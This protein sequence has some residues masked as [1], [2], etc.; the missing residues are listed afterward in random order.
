MA[1]T[2][3]EEVESKIKEL[4]DAD[5]TRLLGRLNRPQPKNGEGG[6][7][8]TYGRKGYVSP[9]T[10]WLRDHSAPYEGMHVAVKDGELVAARPSLKELDAFL[11]K[12]GIDRPLRT[13]IPRDGELLWAGW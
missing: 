11:K 9:N 7:P 12:I 3:I 6:K 13:Y 2:T 10:I 1:I 4:S 8:P 5:R